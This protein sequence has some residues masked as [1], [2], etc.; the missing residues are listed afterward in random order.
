MP[1][2]TVKF[3]V[4]GAVCDHGTNMWD[5]R[6]YERFRRERARPFHDLMQRV[7]LSRVRR[8]ADLGCGT[9]E[10][11]ATLSER[12]PGAR[13]TGV[14]SSAEMLAAAANH[15]VPG[16]LDFVRADAAAWT[17]DGPLDLL[18]S[19]ATL[20]WIPDHARLLPALAGLLAPGGVLAVQMPG[21]FDA[22]SHRLVGEVQREGR[23]AE[24]LAGV[25]RDG[26]VQPAAWYAER[27]FASGFAHADVWET[28]YVHVL[29]GEDAVLE[30]LK[31]TTLRPVLARLP[32]RER[33]EFL[34]ELGARLARAYPRAAHGTLLPFRRLFLVAVR[35]A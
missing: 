29:P 6:Q 32:E 18:V 2:G 17:P 15:A 3:A 1:A 16:R 26:V 8:A 5:V 4:P 20:H 13:I 19:N 12:W 11:T 14:D 24:T 10:L 33:A 23:W 28:T 30:W 9:G 35:P 7:A 31:G 34:G 22:P 27:L 25:E 21:N